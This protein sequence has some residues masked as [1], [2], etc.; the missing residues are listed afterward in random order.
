MGA[1]VA[2]DTAILYGTLSI[3]LIHSLTRSL[4]DMTHSA[5]L[6]VT[7]NNLYSPSRYKATT[8]AFLNS[9]HTSPGTLT[10]RI[11]FAE[12]SRPDRRASLERMLWLKGQALLLVNEGLRDPNRQLSAGTLSDIVT[13]HNYE[14]I[15]GERYVARM[16]RKG[17]THLLNA[18]GGIENI[19]G[20][21]AMLVP[22]ILWT[23]RARQAR[24]LWDPTEEP[25]EFDTNFERG[26]QPLHPL[27]IALLPPDQLGTSAGRG[28]A[29]GV[30]ILGPGVRLMVA[31]DA[32]KQLSAGAAACRMYDNA[33]MA[34][35][36]REKLQQAEGGLN[37]M[38][39]DPQ[40]KTEAAYFTSPR[41]V[42]QQLIFEAARLCGL[43]VARSIAAYLLDRTRTAQ[44]D[45][46]DSIRTIGKLDVRPLLDYYP[47]ILL[48]IL[49]IHGPLRAGGQRSQSVA[50]A[51]R[52]CSK[53]GLDSWDAVKGVLA[54]VYYYP[55]LQEEAGR[56]FWA[57]TVR[58]PS[59]EPRQEPTPPPDDTPRPNET[60]SKFAREST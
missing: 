48:W 31:L 3:H 47:R 7:G 12:A 59:T 49:F 58:E 20:S 38:R 23:D 35:T 15:F 13:L 8:G 60:W 24:R 21:A 41:Y 56:I 57:E 39:R 50:L 6:D 16:H 52:T 19:K 32:L 17:L 54:T 27:N 30:S 44:R 55:E 43:V 22:M 4:A 45:L 26:L 53:I 33:P 2:G 29:I 18:M 1:A 25:P 28:H 5:Y 36:L 14:Q 11:L 10:L 34:A 9:F 51:S 37:A 46:E 40:D 42:L